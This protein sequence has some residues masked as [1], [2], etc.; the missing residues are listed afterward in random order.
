VRAE[1]IEA[2]VWDTIT[3]VLREPDV[4][5]AK[6]E[7]YQV[8]LGARDVEVRSEIEYLTRQ[9]SEAERQEGKLLDLYLVADLEVPAVKARRDKLPRL[10][11]QGSRSKL[12]NV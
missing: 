10:R 5:T 7:A 1:T 3:S 6:L 11:G 9:L 2:L 4:I 8:R 12:Q